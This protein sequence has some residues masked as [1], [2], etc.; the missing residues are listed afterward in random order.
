MDGNL[1][2]VFRLLIAAAAAL[3]AVILAAAVAAFVFG[4]ALPWWGITLVGAIG[5]IVA[6]GVVEP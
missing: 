5:F 4:T 1:A 6:V 3:A 2:F